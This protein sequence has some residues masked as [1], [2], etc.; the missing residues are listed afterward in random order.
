M[1]LT[2]WKLSQKVSLLVARSKRKKKLA[3][4]EE[5]VEAPPEEQSEP[6]QSEDIPTEDG[7]TPHAPGW[8]AA[9][10]A[11]ALLALVLGFLFRESFDLSKLLFAN[12][13]PWGVIH[14]NLTK[15]EGSWGSWSD[16][17]WVGRAGPAAGPSFTTAFGIACRW[18][19]ENGSVIF[20]N[21]YTPISLWLL[22]M[23]AWL[24]FRQL[25]CSAPVCLLGA[26]AATLNGDFFS[27]ACWGL[28][29]VG[30][31]AGMTFLALAAIV[32]IRPGWFWGLP[33]LAGLAVGQAVIEGYDVGALFSLYAAAFG[34]FWVLNTGGLK[35][36][37]FAKGACL[38][39][40][41]ALFAG[42]MAY[43]SIHSLKTTEMDD[44]VKRELKPE[45]KWTMDTQWSLPMEETFRVA[46]PG[47]FGYRMD[48]LEEGVYWGRV[49]QHPE[50]A[51]YLNQQKEEVEKLALRA[52]PEQRGMISENSGAIAM[53][54]V[55]QFLG[56]SFPGWNH[57]GYGV[58]AGVMVLIVAFWALVSSFRFGENAPYSGVERRL[59]WFCATLTLGSLLLAWGRHAPFY[60]MIH[61]LPFFS[62]IRNPIK[63]MHPFSI[64]IV[65]M[66][67]LGLKGMA[68]LYLEGSATRVKLQYNTLRD[69]VNPLG[70]FESR[71]LMISVV[72]LICATA[73]LFFYT[74]SEGSLMSYLQPFSA[75]LA[76]ISGT[77]PL[78]FQEV[79]G[80]SGDII[81]DSFS[82]A[83]LSL[84]F[85]FLF[86]LMVGWI[87]L[88]RLTGSKVSAVWV[89]MLGFM[90]LD[91]SQGSAPYKKHEDKALKYGDSA[92]FKYLR[93][94][95][96]R[97][98][99][100]SFPGSEEL[101]KE[102]PQLSDRVVLMPGDV[103]SQV[104][105]SAIVVRE[106]T[107]NGLNNLEMREFMGF[108]SY[109]MSPTNNTVAIRKSYES[110]MQ[111]LL[112]R[113]FDNPTFFQRLNDMTTL[114]LS[115]KMSG[116][117]GRLS[118][119]ANTWRQHS[120]PEHGI[121]T[122]DI[123]Q[124]PRPL[125]KDENYMAAFRPSPL[126][127]EPT[128]KQKQEYNQR[129]TELL[130][131]QWELTSARYIL[132]ISGN[133]WFDFIANRQYGDIGYR[134]A[135]NYVLD[136]SERRFR[137]AR[138]YD[139]QMVNIEVDKRIERRPRM[140]V[141]PN[142]EVALTEFTGALPRAKLY[143]DWR[144]GL[145][146]NATLKMLSSAG[147]DPHQQVLLADENLEAPI[148]P[149]RTQ[150]F[151]PVEM[152][153][154][155]TIKQVRLKTPPT[156]VP[157]VLL[158]ND[159]YSPDWKVYVDGKE[160]DLLRANYLMRGV[161]LEPSKEGHEVEFR[162]EPD[163][164]PLYF[165]IGAGVFGLLIGFVG[166][167][168]RDADELS[169]VQSE[170]D[171]TEIEESVNDSSGDEE[172]VEDVGVEGVDKKDD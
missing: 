34:I 103:D 101:Q 126:P 48:T 81:K 36:K 102:I 17:N 13:A 92:L 119:E 77:N 144:Q 167:F 71:W 33:V 133:T 132:C 156:T 14:H 154:E 56:P 163:T 138:T 91:L 76:N 57:S 87:S 3:S 63:F 107:T 124:N 151:G 15:G 23:C 46:I 7:K 121:F 134:S 60:S 28:P 135:L 41:M 143:S 129:R 4:V 169:N 112:K 55:R 152:L 153:G 90:V 22:G 38:V 29:S 18:F 145:D 12:D 162:Y 110:Y 155:Q 106:A 70:S 64:L 157:A 142:G 11:A 65:V 96:N 8:R 122:L 6:T 161:H 115:R 49:G 118:M 141:E 45:D 67:G 27:Y 130:L 159:R 39:A 168:R 62:S 149:Q 89:V 68:R 75:M 30:L 109:L 164:G 69:L 84:G 54:R 53:A 123:V 148:D 47:L 170:E 160:K 98:V 97:G 172:E 85:M 158:L 131:R 43:H 94:Q 80:V 113:G 99:G 78:E 61:G 140:V 114:A 42:L 74:L 95:P 66:F 93:T 104:L 20:S 50:V 2:S 166:C 1:T 100:P 26:L 136:P 51:N 72:T 117:I 82:R 32:S 9:L 120:F 24:F 19:G 137:T 21:F 139:K 128:D 40:V 35:V 146:D 108:G 58:Y 147:F 171:S 73:G 105:N 31:A 5:S 125:V 37:Y 79:S 10:L 44:V 16:G 25:D 52:P 88:G 111:S 86:L 59:I 165:S 83:T 150:D 116:A 127:P